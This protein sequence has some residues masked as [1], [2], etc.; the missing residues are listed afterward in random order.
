MADESL[1]QRRPAGAHH[2]YWAIN[3]QLNPIDE[4]DRLVAGYCRQGVAVDYV[5]DPATEHIGL[6]AT[7]APGALAYLADRFAGRPAPNGCAKLAG[8]TGSRPC[9]SRRAPIGSRNIGRVRLGLTRRRLERIGVAPVRRTR[10]TYVYC[11]KGSRKRVVAVLSGARAAGRVRLVATTATEHRM[12][13]VGPG[14]PSRRLAAR[15]PRGRRLTGTLFR[16]GPAS[17]RLFGTRRGRVRYV[18]VAGR[19]VLR[20]RGALR[21]HL[22]RAGS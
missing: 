17:R 7:G 16:A 2:V 21:R 10:F 19:S 11:V 3:D 1:G 6:A 12:R 18:A 15:F 9:L 22:R 14:V 5:R 20:D 8:M 4:G 13:R